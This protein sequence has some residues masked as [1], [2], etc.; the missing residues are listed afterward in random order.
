M[1]PNKPP[2]KC[3]TELTQQRTPPADRLPLIVISC[4]AQC[5][6]LSLRA[7][8]GSPG[9]GGPPHRAVWL[10]LPRPPLAGEEPKGAD[11][12]YFH[13]CVSQ[14]QA[15]PPATPLRR[16]NLCDLNLQGHCQAFTGSQNFMS[17]DFKPMT[18]NTGEHLRTAWTHSPA[19][20]RS[21]L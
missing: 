11:R 1:S 7:P 18:E 13:V 10:A 19:W 9:L 4:P 16:L 5:K 14:T 21:A 2:R 17:K 20:I 6:G 3:P 8:Q 12:S 15:N